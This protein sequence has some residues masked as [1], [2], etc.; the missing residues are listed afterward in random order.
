LEEIGEGR[1]VV[2]NERLGGADEGEA[3][4]WRN[5]VMPDGY[6][7][8]KI[9]K[10]EDAMRMSLYLVISNFVFQNTYNAAMFLLLF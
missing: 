9:K 7:G 1:E 2:L 10:R 8:S 5:R 3:N 4:E 6:Q